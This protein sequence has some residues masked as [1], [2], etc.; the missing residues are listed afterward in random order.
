M[1]PNKF[2]Q[3]SARNVEDLID[4]WPLAFMVSDG[5]AGF[6]ATPLPMLA[7]T[8]GQ[9]EIIR[10]VGHM[11]R[12]N[13]QMSELEKNPQAYFLFQGPQGYISPTYVND[14]G[15]V[16]TWNYGVVRIKADICF[17][18]DN[19]DYALSR[20]VNRMERGRENAWSVEEV[21]D[22]YAQLTK[23]IIAFTATVTDVDATFKLGQDEKPGIL[24]QIIS[25][26]ENSDLASWMRL[27]NKV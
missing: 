21:G 23:A 14:R 8:N 25:A 2:K 9:G 12:S 13:P 6:M 16:P 10:L 3:Y 1:P 17:Q 26:T 11:A 15:W 24:A 18:P 7:D 20:L 4:A 22:R 27:F 5:P 19:I